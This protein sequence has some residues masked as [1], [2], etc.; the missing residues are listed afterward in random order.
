MLSTLSDSAALVLLTE[1]FR[2]SASV[3]SG[4]P[5][6]VIIQWIA[7]TQAQPKIVTEEVRGALLCRLNLNFNGAEA[8]LARGDGRFEGVDDNRVEFCSSKGFDFSQ[9]VFEVHCGLVGPV[10][11]HRV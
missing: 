1:A 3:G 10:R 4:L 7:S 5:K 9:R 2:R 6:R 8:E 11:G